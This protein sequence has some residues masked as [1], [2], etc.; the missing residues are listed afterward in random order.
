M[1]LLLVKQVNLGQAVLTSASLGML[2]SSKKDEHLTNPKYLANLKIDKP[3]VVKMANLNSI[4]IALITGSF[5]MA[6]GIFFLLYGLEKPIYSPVLQKNPQGVDSA[7]QMRRVLLVLQQ[8]LACRVPVVMV[9]LIVCGTLGSLFRLKLYGFA[10]L[11]VLVVLSGVFTIITGAV[12]V[13]PAIKLFDGVSP[14]TSPDGMQV[15]LEPIVRLHRNVGV[16]VAVTLIL[17]LAST[18]F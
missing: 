17:Q 7:A 3:K 8:F 4:L 18:A 2:D 10:P 13:R 9:T 12:L 15:A 11:P 6:S 5:G 14:K 16:L 1:K